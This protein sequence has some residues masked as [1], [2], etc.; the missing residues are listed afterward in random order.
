MQGM[1]QDAPL[2]GENLYDG[3]DQDGDDAPLQGEHLHDEDDQD[4][5][6]KVL[7][8]F[9]VLPLNTNF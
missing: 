2:Q 3:G 4:E 6:D 7:L 1:P 9:F 8:R 5:H